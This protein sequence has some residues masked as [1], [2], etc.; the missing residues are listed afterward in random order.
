MGHAEKGDDSSK[1][2]KAGDRGSRRSSNR[3][4]EQF[5]KQ[6]DTSEPSAL[7]HKF[8]VGSAALA[9]SSPE[10]DTT[11]NMPEKARRLMRNKGALMR[12]DQ[13]LPRSKMQRKH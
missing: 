4:D 6:T 9:F 12:P 2:K 3:F 8:L 10:D 11:E 1:Q 5:K 13:E 7:R